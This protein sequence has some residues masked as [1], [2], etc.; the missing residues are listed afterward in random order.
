MLNIMQE[1]IS[2]FMMKLKFCMLKLMIGILII[3][4][5]RQNLEKQ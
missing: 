3:S 2:D 4:K 5:M 1:K